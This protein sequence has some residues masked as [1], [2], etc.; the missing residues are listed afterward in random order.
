MIH[1]V[2]PYFLTQRGHEVRQ[3]EK[4]GAAHKESGE[5]ELETEQ[6]HWQE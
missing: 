3:R 1:P 6:M 4:A 5:K 2:H